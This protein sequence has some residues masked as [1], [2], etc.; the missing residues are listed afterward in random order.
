[1]VIPKGA[2]DVMPCPTRWPSALPLLAAALHAL[3]PALPQVRRKPKIPKGARD[4]MP[5]QMAIREVA[6]NRIT[7]VFKRHGAVSIDT[8]VFELR[9][10]GCQPCTPSTL[11]EWVALLPGIDRRSVL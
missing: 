2:T 7:S 11:D 9:C 8:P 3:F 5:D 4:F 1:M 6:F 10:G